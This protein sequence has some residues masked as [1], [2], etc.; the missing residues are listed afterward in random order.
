MKFKP[1]DVSAAELDMTPMIDIVFQLITFFMVINKF[2]Q[3]EADERVGLPRDTLARPPAV[4]RKNAFVL[5][6][7]YMK[8]QNGERLSNDPFLFIGDE[9]L[10]LE[11]VR[12]RLR[13]ES[14]FYRTIGTSLEDVTVEIRAD[15]SV[16]AGLVQEL[17]QMCQ[18]TGIEFQRFALKATQAAVQ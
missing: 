5:N 1:A 6:Y 2:D 18:E 14:Q 16:K 17:I 15:A 3:D 9:Q 4:Q 13:Q 8:N 7:G 12:P 11:Q 10:T